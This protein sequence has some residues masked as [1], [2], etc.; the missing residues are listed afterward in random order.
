MI[1]SAKYITIILLVCINAHGQE[2]PEVKVNHLS[3]TVSFNDLKTIRESSFVND[4]LAVLE[5][6]ITKNDDQT[7]S[8]TNFIY[9]YSNYLELFET[10]ETSPRMGFLT[11]VFSVDKIGDIKMLKRNT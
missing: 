6:R 1:N 5:A 11:I 4:T 9:G 10:S 3:F 8:T 2:I 7:T